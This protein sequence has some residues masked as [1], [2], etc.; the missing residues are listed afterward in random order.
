MK[1]EIP[2]L[3]N[4]SFKFTFDLTIQYINKH[5][6]YLNDSTRVDALLKLILE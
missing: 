2:T 4:I 1:K 5:H 3:S 6:S